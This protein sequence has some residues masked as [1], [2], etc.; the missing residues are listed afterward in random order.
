M[1][2]REVFCTQTVGGVF[3]FFFSFLSLSS[4]RSFLGRNSS[5]RVW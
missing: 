1:D 2:L 5:K 3:A 4:L